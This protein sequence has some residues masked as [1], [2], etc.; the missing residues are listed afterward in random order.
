MNAE[1]ERDQSA[2]GGNSASYRPGVKCSMKSP[3]KTKG[4]PKLEALLEEQVAPQTG[5]AA[6]APAQP[7]EAKKHRKTL[8]SLF[9][10]ETQ[11]PAANLSD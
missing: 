7:M 6:A 11:A 4:T 5:A 9:K 1:T 2:A 8:G 10:K 3:I